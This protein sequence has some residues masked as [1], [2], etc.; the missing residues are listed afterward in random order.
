MAKQH[1]LNQKL[2]KQIL[3]SGRDE[4]FETIVSESNV[5]PTTVAVFLTETSKALKRG[6]TEVDRVSEHQIRQI[7][8]CLSSGKLLKESISDVIVWL[9]KNDGKSVDEAINTLGLIA[10]PEDELENVVEKIIADHRE[11]IR[12]RGDAAF[13]ILMGII[14]KSHRG[15]VDAA[16]ISRLL[17]EKLKSLQQ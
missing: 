11:V 14:M 4:L 5:S 13:G 2:A 3:D 15:K 7:F 10:V 9:S 16:Q 1:K 17:K 8:Q 12:E 6:G